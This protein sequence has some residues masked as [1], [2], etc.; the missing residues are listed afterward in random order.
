MR[1]SLKVMRR[2]IRRASKIVASKAEAVFVVLVK[3][4]SLGS[5]LVGL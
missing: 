4:F 2:A 5:A 3:V 1:G